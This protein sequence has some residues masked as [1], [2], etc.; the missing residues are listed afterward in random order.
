MPTDRETD[1]QTNAGLHITSLAEVKPTRH[2]PYH[3]PPG[4]LTRPVNQRQPQAT[5]RCLFQRVEVVAA[6][7][8]YFTRTSKVCNVTKKLKPKVTTKEQ[9]VLCAFH[10]RFYRQT[11]GVFRR[12]LGYL[13]RMV[14]NTNFGRFLFCP[15][16]CNAGVWGQ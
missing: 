9:L 11:F 12:K 6:K 2:R 10:R 8:H 14:C 4:C 5:S 7:C 1:R 16:L 13:Y 3:R 15:S